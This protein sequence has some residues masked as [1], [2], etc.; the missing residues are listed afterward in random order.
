MLFLRVLMIIAAAR[1]PWLDQVLA[2]A[3]LAVPPARPVVIGSV[4]FPFGIV[5]WH[6]NVHFHRWLP[7]LALPLSFGMDFPDPLLQSAQAAAD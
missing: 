6:Q 2:P 7:P 4:L 3:Q 5:G 1:P